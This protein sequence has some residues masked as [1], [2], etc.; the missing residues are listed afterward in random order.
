MAESEIRDAGLIAQTA[1]DPRL[2]AVNDKIAELVAEALFNHLLRHGLI[3]SPNEPK[4]PQQ[5]EPH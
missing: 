3:P 5:D 1:V 4:E 2:E